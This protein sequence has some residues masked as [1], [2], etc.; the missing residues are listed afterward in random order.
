MR[1]GPTKLYAG[2]M[3]ENIVQAL[4]R[5]AVFQQMLK[6]HNKLVTMDNPE[7]ELRFRVVGTVHD[8]NITVVPTAVA[9]RMKAFMEKVMSTAPVWAPGLPV[10]CEVGIGTRYGESKG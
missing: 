2:R 5:I 1:K 6:I 10:S 7:R 3:V 9:E 8:E 4:A